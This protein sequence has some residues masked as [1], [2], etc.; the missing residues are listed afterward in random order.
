MGCVCARARVCVCACACAR[1]ACV[2]ARMCVCTRVVVLAHIRRLGNPLCPGVGRTEPLLWGGNY[3]M[4]AHCP[5]Q[6]A[7]LWRDYSCSTQGS[8]PFDSLLHSQ[9]LDQRAWP[10]PQSCPGTRDSGSSPCC[11]W[12]QGLP[13]QAG[14]S[15]STQLV[16]KKQML[17]VSSGFSWV[18]SGERVWGS[19]SPVREELST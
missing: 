12:K 14:L 18:N 13:N 16:E 17:R 3:S 2:C 6:F 4:E 5:S 7:A 9:A 1:R 11:C 10:Q 8:R 19:D 15:P